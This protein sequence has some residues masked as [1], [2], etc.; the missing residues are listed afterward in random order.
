MKREKENTN[1]NYIAAAK[2][3][4]SDKKLVLEYLKGE[5]TLTSLKNEGIILARLKWAKIECF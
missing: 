5:K 2:K 1:A 3:M 4:L